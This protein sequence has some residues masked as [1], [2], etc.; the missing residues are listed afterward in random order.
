MTE[1][2]IDDRVRTTFEGRE[3]P[4]VYK[5]V[6]IHDGNAQ[7]QSEHDGSI[8]YSPIEELVVCTDPPPGPLNHK[9]Q[10][11]VMEFAAFVRKLDA[12]QAES[13]LALLGALLE[14]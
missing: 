1:F 14:G 9:Q 10:N 3:F 11:K 7:L 5:I 12:E 8:T 6:G 4:G 13:A 2:K